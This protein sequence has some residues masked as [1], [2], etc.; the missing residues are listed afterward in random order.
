MS[1]EHSRVAFLKGVRDW[2]QMIS[3]IS[4]R[5]LAQLRR[6]FFCRARCRLVQAMTALAGVPR[7]SCVL[8]LCKFADFT[9]IIYPATIPGLQSAL[10]ELFK[11]VADAKCTSCVRSPRT[12]QFWSFVSQRKTIEISRNFSFS[13]SQISR[14]CSQSFTWCVRASNG[15]PA[16]CSA[17][18]VELAT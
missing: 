11:L 8:W 5:I 15:A 3:R 17:I 18:M 2:L 10:Q 6:S 1:A 16:L 4:L 14:E 13:G 12:V 7:G 9:T